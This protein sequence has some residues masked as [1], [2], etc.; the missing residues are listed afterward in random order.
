M[1]EKTGWAVFALTCLGIA[2]GLLVYMFSRSRDADQDAWLHFGA[3][4][5]IAFAWGCGFAALS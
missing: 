2:I 3:M 4:I 5:F 1:S